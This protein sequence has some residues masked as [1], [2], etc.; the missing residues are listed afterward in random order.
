MAGFL[1]NYPGCPL[2]GLNMPPRS[3]DMYNPMVAGP[4]YG[5]SIVH[6]LFSG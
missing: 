2:G 3:A 4:P 5:R 6:G 1:N